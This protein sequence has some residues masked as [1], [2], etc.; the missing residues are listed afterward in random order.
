RV[1]AVLL[2]AA[3]EGYGGP[4]GEGVLP[5]LL[6]VEL[7]HAY[8]LMHDDW[9]DEDEVRRGGPTVHAML[10]EAYGSPRMGEIGAILAGDL[11]AGYALE[12]LSKTPVSSE[13]LAEAVR[14]LARIQVD[15]VLGQT[16]DV[17]ESDDV[18][19]M[20][21]LK[22][23]SYTVRGPLLLGAALAGAGA[24]EKAALEDF[25]RPLGIAFQLRDDLLG[26][27]GDPEKTGKSTASDLRQGKRT[28][29]VHELLTG[30][31]SGEDRALMGRVLGVKDP[32]PEDVARVIERLRTGGPKD[33]V[34]AKLGAL[35]E[36]ARTLLERTALAPATRDVLTGA[37]SALG[38]RER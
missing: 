24:A 31:A 25:A 14:E 9:M 35:L 26:T 15:V 22:T 29:L 6:A 8:L 12:A 32:S 18:E 3:C 10:R 7:L 4:R 17:Y 28:A 34:E 37:I 21:D 5:A 1:R 30:D 23:N 19:S 33:R 20:H 11:V 36:E 2:A 16:L 13:R 38:E 27:F